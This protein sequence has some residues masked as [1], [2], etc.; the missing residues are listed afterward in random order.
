MKIKKRLRTCRGLAGALGASMLLAGHAS[1]QSE[2]APIPVAG[3][4]APVTTATGTELPQVLVTARKR[5]EREQDVPASI[6]AFTSTQLD[7]L[8]VNDIRDLGTYVPGLQFTDLAGYNLIYLRGVGT[9]AFIPS[10]DP[11]VATYLDGVYFPSGH[12]VAQSF[13]AVERVEVLK[14]PQGTLFGRNSTG[15][16]ISIVTENPGDTPELSVQ[17]S[18]T[19]RFDD[20]RA[21]IYAT[22]PVTSWL[23]GSVS[24]FYD[25]AHNYYTRDPASGPPLPEEVNDGA[26]FKL[27]FHDGEDLS[28]VVS[29]LVM[30]QTG[31]S[32]TTSVNTH[33]SPILGALIPAETQ[34]YVVT[35][36]SGPSLT[37]Q[38]RALYA[39]AEWK[40]PWFNT[41]LT[42]SNY[43]RTGITCA[44]PATPPTC[45]ATTMPHRIA[46]PAPGPTSASPAKAAT[47]PARGTWPGPGM[48]PTQEATRRTKG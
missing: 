28:L 17:V 20:R 26:R 39:I 19:P 6:S 44:R 1:A 33:P 9:D 18:D 8:G 7:A 29:G 38:T 48:S 31:T 14:G 15:G 21:R 22:T 16:A 37:T 13:G 27:R 23:S 42:G 36:N 47:V 40:Q 30:R 11:S 24:G 3:T 32:T 43:T 45:G 34:D 10:A 46:T 41:K 4:D 25:R 35:A 5:E 2:A 12:S